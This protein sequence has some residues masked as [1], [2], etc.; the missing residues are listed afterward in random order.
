MKTQNLRI[1][2]ESVDIF[3][4]QVIF[5]VTNVNVSLSD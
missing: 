2:P 4:V 3:E 5:K 1:K